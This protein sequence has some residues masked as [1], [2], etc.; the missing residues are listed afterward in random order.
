MKVFAATAHYYFYFHNL[1]PQLPELFLWKVVPPLNYYSKSKTVFQ[2]YAC[3]E[4]GWFS[5]HIFLRYTKFSDTQNIF[6][7]IN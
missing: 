4:F 7:M 1:P 3:Q 5:E 6:N 2:L